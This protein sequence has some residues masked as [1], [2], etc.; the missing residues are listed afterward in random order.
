[1]KNYKLSPIGPAGSFRVWCRVM[2]LAKVNVS[3]PDKHWMGPP[4]PFSAYRWVNASFLEKLQN[5]LTFVLNIFLRFCLVIFWD[6][7]HYSQ[8]RL[9]WSQTQFILSQRQHNFQLHYGHRYRHYFLRNRYTKH[10]DCINYLRM[11]V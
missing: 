10:K 8:F 3:K 7:F 1:M 11:R 6:I 4:G 2:N 9:S 5:W